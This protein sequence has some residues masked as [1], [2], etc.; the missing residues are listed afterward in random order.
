MGARKG[1]GR[2]RRNG[3]H[4][5]ARDKNEA[6]S[7]GRESKRGVRRRGTGKWCDSGIIQDWSIPV[8]CMARMGDG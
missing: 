7:T 1:A 8:L 3:K 6:D 5:N 2:E 4:K